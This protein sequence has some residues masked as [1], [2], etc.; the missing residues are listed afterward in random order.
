[1]R[2]HCAVSRFIRLLIRTFALLPIA[3]LLALT[4]A[5]FAHPGH[6]RSAAEAGPA[7][8][9]VEAS[10]VTRRGDLPEL[11]ERVSAATPDHG[12]IVADLPESPSPCP[13]CDEDDFCGGGASFPVEATRMPLEAELGSLVTPAPERHRPDDP[14]D[15]PPKPPR[16]HV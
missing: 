8:R 11:E 3:L 16:I 5:A 4:P 7:Q 1:M 14:I 9:D 6:E 15:I 2:I 10:A 13:C 12:S